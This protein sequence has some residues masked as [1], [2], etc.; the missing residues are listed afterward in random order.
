[1][2]NKLNTKKIMTAGILAAGGIGFLVGGIG[3]VHNVGAA[4]ATS[5]TQTQTQNQEKGQRGNRVQLTD[6]QKQ[7][8]EQLRNEAIASLSSEDQATL[9]TLTAKG[10]FS[11]TF[12]EH[13][14][15]DAIQEKVM[16]YMSAHPQEGL[17]T[18]PANKGRGGKG[19]ISENLTDAQK[20]ELDKLK[21]EGIAQLTS[22]E[23]SRLKELDTK[24]RMSL[25]E[26]ERQELRT[27]TEK[28]MTYVKSKVSFTMPEGPKQKGGRGHGQQPQSGNETPE[29]A[30]R[31]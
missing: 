24:D 23:Q 30:P 20:A 21:A 22:E 17:P 11:L 26:Q 9:K 12:A 8:L 18:P 15:L 13:E 16:A 14:Q 7:K 29:Q 25:T 31:A 28:V 19:Q 6:E 2:K 10:H 1:M 5:T 3:F 27:L 4:P